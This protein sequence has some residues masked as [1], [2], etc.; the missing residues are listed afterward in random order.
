MTQTTE[1][2]VSN[3]INQVTEKANSITVS[4]GLESREAT[5]FVRSLKV[6]MDEVEGFFRPDIDN[7]HKTHKDLCTKLNNFMAP[8]RNAE[9]VVKRKIALFA[10][11]EQER[12]D[13][14]QAAERARAKVKAD[15]ER[16]ALLAKAVKAEEKCDDKKAAELLERSSMV[17]EEPKTIQPVIAQAGVTQRMEYE[18]E[19]ID[20]S[21]VPEE[22]KTVDTALIKRIVKSFKGKT[23]IPGIKIIEVPDVSIRK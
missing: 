10:R 22:Y 23:K 6:H 16:E 14:E 3:N 5:D 18:I 17:R 11:A 21:L 8:L 12:I 7:A 19:V 1:L 9:M 15:Q 2:E 4:N 20:K 13:K